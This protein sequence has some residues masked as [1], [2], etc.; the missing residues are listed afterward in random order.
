MGSADGLI[1]TINV[2]QYADGVPFASW[3]RFGRRPLT[4]TRDRGMLR[5]VYP[6]ATQLTGDLQVI[7]RL[8]DHPDGPVTSTQTDLFDLSLTQEGHFVA[9]YRRSRY[10]ELE[11]RRDDGDP[12]EMEGF[13][14]DIYTGGT[15]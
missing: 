1:Y 7:T 14:T 9:P 15:R 6:F 11:F 3:V 4:S 13:D 8:S 2:A 12:W 5:R 10:Y